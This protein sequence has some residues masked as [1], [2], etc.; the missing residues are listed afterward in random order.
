MFKISCNCKRRDPQLCFA[1]HIT[2]PLCMQVFTFTWREDIR[3]GDPQHT[4]K[5]CFD[6]VSHT[7]PVTL[8]DCHG[9]KGNQLWKYRK[10]RQGVE[11]SL[12]DLKKKKCASPLLSRAPSLMPLLHKLP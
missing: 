11:G 7:S 8:Y 9:M 1:A 10:V 2:A 3:P 4:K 6:A 5:S 12:L